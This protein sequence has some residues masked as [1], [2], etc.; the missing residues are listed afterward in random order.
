MRRQLT[1]LPLGDIVLLNKSKEA[2]A[3]T[4]NKN[5]IFYLDIL[6]CFAAL[7]VILLHSISPFMINERIFGTNSW[8]LYLLA[9]AFARAGVPLFLMISGTLLL[10]D[11]RSLDVGAFYKKRLPKILIPLVFWNIAYYLFYI[12]LDGTADAGIL[13]FFE[14]FINSGTSYHLWY[15]YTAL[16]VYL[17]TPFIK[18][19]VDSCSLGQLVIFE[20]L[21]CFCSTL[22]PLVN[23]T[24]GIYV[25]LFEPLANGYIG[26][27]I[28]GYILSR[29]EISRRRTALAVSGTVSASVGIILN[30]VINQAASSSDKINLAANGGYHITSFLIAGGLFILARVIFENSAPNKPVSALSNLTFGVYLVHVMISETLTRYLT[31]ST[32]PW[33]LSSIIFAATAVISFAAI[34]LLKKIKFIKNYL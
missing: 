1:F 28:L 34:F 5:R 2:L 27:F 33:A 11:T 8:Y 3:V 10:N 32:A 12:L 22:R 29:A 6:R 18:R 19:I 21:V 16:A 15:L 25:Y 30:I 23:T 20:L 9:N 4:D 17:L 7:S 13:D 31:L 26:Y 24:F 14:K